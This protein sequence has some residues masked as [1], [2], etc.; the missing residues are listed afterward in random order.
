MQNIKEFMAENHRH[1][2]DFFIAA[3]REVAAGSWSLAKSAFTKFRD[4]ML[5]HFAAEE[6]LLF[7][8]FENHTGIYMGPTQVMR[9]EHVQLCELIASAEDA[10]VAQ[11]SEAYQGEAETLLIMM[12]QHNMKEESILYPMCDQHLQN[13]TDTLLPLLQEAV[14]EVEPGK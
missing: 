7:P 13:Q 5:R 9:G 4:A 3:E 8:A 6:S 11:D 10:L 2:D 12:Q 1:C 14:R